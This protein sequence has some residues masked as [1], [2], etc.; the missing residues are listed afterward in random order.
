V[1]H[2]LNI[3]DAD[4]IVGM[5]NWLLALLDHIDKLEARIELGP[6]VDRPWS[7]NVK[8]VKDGDKTIVSMEWPPGTNPEY[9]QAMLQDMVDRELARLKGV[10]E[11]GD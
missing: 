4:L 5:R 2:G 6:P 3:P 8:T 10:E 1:A 9:A 7:P 11:T